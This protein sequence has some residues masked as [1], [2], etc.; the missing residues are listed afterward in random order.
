MAKKFAELEK[1]MKPTSLK[2]ARIR[3]KEMMAEMLLNEIRK[4]AGLTQDALAKALK[5]KQPSLSKLETQD[6]MQIS[7][8]RKIIHALGGE[9]ELVA[10]LPQGDIRINQFQ[11]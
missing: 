9:L 3:A 5:I 1:K 8:L 4:E 11:N 2:R 10:H 7:T 6:D